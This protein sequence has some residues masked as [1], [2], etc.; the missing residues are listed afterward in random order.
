MSAIFIL[1]LKRYF[2]DSISIAVETSFLHWNITF[3]SVTFCLSKNRSNA[4]VI[5]FT[6]QHNINYIKNIH[7]YLFITPININT[8]DYYCKGLNSTCGVDIHIARKILLTQFCDA[9]MAKVTYLDDE[10]RNCEEIFKFHEL[11]M[12]YC[13]V[14]NNIIDF[15]NIDALPLRFSSLAP[16][17]SIKIFLRAALFWKYEMYVHSNEDIPYFG[18]LSHS[19]GQDNIRYLYDIE[20]MQNSADVKTES[21]KKRK[22]KFPHEMVYGSPYK[23]SFSSCMSDLRIV[24]EL[25]HCNC[26]LYIS[27]KKYFNYYCDFLGILCV[28]RADITTKAKQISREKYICYPSCSELKLQFVGSNEIIKTSYSEFTEVEIKVQNTPS[29]RCVRSVTQTQLDLIVSAGGVLGLFAG[30]SMLSAIEILY[31]SLKNL[32]H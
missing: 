23:Y 16:R 7:N 21:F 26:T 2:F 15:P 19:L 31:F 24:L 8:K 17:K 25:K 30:T 9:I 12:G 20:E 5:E 14:A 29:L 28:S 27:P 18:M 1:M 11:E 22:C 3:P 13:F 32:I 4:E 6:K 10:Y